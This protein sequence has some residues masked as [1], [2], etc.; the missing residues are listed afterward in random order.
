[1]STMDELPWFLAPTNVERLYTEGSYLVV[2]F[3]ATGPNYASPLDPTSN[4]VLGCWHIVDKLGN[5]TKKYKFGNEYE[6]AELLDDIKSVDFIV[7]QNAK[8]EL[9]WLKRCGLE[10]RDVL[11]YDTMLGAWVLDGNRTKPRD[12][13]SLASR[14]DIQGKIDVVSKLIKAGVPVEDIPPSWLLE[15]CDQDVQITRVVFCNQK[16]E[17]SANQQWHLVHTRNLCCSVL[18]DIEFEGLTL[19]SEM[20]M[21]EYKRVRELSLSIGGQLAEMTGGINLGSPKQLA[22]FLYDTLGM[23]EPKDHRGKEIRTGKGDRTANS[24]ALALLVP[25]TEEQKKF[26]ELYKEYN[27]AQS[28]LEKNLDYF[29]LT[30]EQKEATFFGNLRQAVVQ[31]GRLASSGIPVIFEGMKKAKSVQLQNIPREY[32]SLF[33]SGQEDWFVMEADSSQLEFRV[34]VEMGGPDPVGY[35]EV[36][37]GVDIH[38]FTAKVITEAGEPTTR[39]GA[40]EKTFRPLYGGSSGT[41]AVRAYCEFFKKK[42]VG[43]SS[44]Q[45]TWTLKCLDKGWFRTPYGMQFYFPD[46]KMM[47]SGHVTNMQSIYNYPVQGYATGEIIPIALV[48]FWHRVRGKN[49]KP[50]VTIHDSIVSRVHKDSVQEAQDIAKQALTLDVYAYLRVVYKTEFKTPL[51]LGIK[52]ARNWGATKEETK[53]D[54][55]PD[56][57]VIDRT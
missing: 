33:W 12:L 32:K 26:L 16:V 11:A 27:K 55:F 4:L 44:T 43:I 2:D 13:N 57:T 7:A 30:C 28:L 45:R 5:V 38:S 49:I 39:Q 29:K 34:A 36:A 53:Y 18:S 25:K 23:D 41:P 14:Y 24:K 42:Y 8:Y 31:T 1:M 3:E 54:V 21:A 48:Y 10:L 56:G 40:K 20:V 19:D 50:F 15:Y 51:G 52:V 35:E 47:R 6:Y 9:Q 17:L 46:T 22:T 37:S